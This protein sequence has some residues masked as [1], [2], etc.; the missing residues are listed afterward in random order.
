MADFQRIG[1]ELGAELSRFGPAA[2]IGAIVAA[3]PAAV[4]DGVARNAWPERVGRDGTLFVA[5]SGAAWAFELTQ[6]APEILAKLRAALGDDCPPLL[7]FAPGKLPAQGPEAA[8]PAPPP[9][10]QATPEEVAT[11]GAWTD[12]IEAPEL[13]EAVA[14]AARASLARAR[15]NRPL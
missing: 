11:A 4:G 7:R 14:R 3:W 15:G 12:A 8:P 5:T 1:D 10:L 9:L 6:L 2:G 13:R